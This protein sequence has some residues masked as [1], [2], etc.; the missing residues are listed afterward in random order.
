MGKIIQVCAVLAFLSTACS[1]SEAPVQFADPGSRRGPSIEKIKVETAVPGLTVQTEAAGFTAWKLTAKNDSNDSMSILWDESSFVAGDGTS[2]RRLIPGNIRR[3]DLEKPHAPTPLAPHSTLIETVYS[4]FTANIERYEYDMRHELN[5]GR[6]YLAVAGSAGRRTWTGSVTES[7]T[8]PLGWWCFGSKDDTT[9][10]R[11]SA[12]CEKIL[13]IAKLRRTQNG[14]TD[15][16]AEAAMGLCRDQSSA[17]C[18][19]NRDG[20][21]CFVTMAECA[22][23][24]QTPSTEVGCA[25]RR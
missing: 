12:K 25:E 22:S 7:D 9:C 17:Y 5:G 2:W 21:F 19:S 10:E 13:N 20:S 1:R 3:M 15:A 16:A 18:A 11:N 8:K 24:A 4:E 6:L 23:F 14:M